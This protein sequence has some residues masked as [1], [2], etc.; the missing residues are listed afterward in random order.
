MLCNA[1]YFTVDYSVICYT[2][3]C[4][5]HWWHPMAG[6]GSKIQVNWWTGINVEANFHIYIVMK[7]Y[8]LHCIKLYC[9]ALETMETFLS[10]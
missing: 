5:V 3:L 8:A 4:I 7:C 9:N 6:T 1:L 2:T 10:V